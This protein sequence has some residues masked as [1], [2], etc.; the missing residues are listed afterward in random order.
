MT[1]TPLA[2]AQR[3]VFPVTLLAG[4]AVGVALAA[5]PSALL[6]QNAKKGTPLPNVQVVAHDA[7][8]RVDITVDGKPFTSY[9]WP[10]TL[11]KPVLFPLRSPEG[12]DLTRG[13][14]PRP[15]ERADHPHHVGLWFNYGDVA[16]IDFWNNSDATAG[17]P[18]MG[19]IVHKAVSNTKSGAGEGSLEVS[20]DWVNDDTKA[21]M[22]KEATRLVFHATGTTRVIDRIT[23]LTAA[24][25][26][27][28]FGDSKEGMYGMRLRR[29]LEMPVKGPAEFTDASGKVTKVAELDNT[30]VTGNYLTSE[31]K[32][33]DAAWGTR[34]NWCALSGVVDNEP[35]TIALFDHPSNP[36]HPAYWHARNYGLFAVNP[37][38]RKQYDD[39]Q[40]AQH[41]TIEAGGSQRFLFRVVIFHGK[42]TAA[43]LDAA[44]KEYA[45]DIK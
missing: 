34:A 5:A 11:K 33:G 32:E 45:K 35:V 29:P 31:G 2:R 6:A 16:G 40:E 42:P 27:V 43:E 17:K 20:A 21:V 15:G 44:Y 9:I 36:N 37:L 1:T 38:G 8:R 25:G 24:S 12:T 4:T 30:G 14:P 23:T 13:F 39:K 3:A 10:T 22:L 28:T 18:K 7:D 26:A 19:T 41:F